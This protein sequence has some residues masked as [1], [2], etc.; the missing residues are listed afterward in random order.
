MVV[1]VAHDREQIEQ[2]RLDRTKFPGP[3]RQRLAELAK[4]PLFVARIGADAPFASQCFDQTSR[5]LRA[6]IV[7]ALVQIVRV[8]RRLALKGSPVG[9]PSQTVAQRLP[10]QHAW[11]ITSM[12]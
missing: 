12:A 3:L 2:P 9:R 11:L 10:E 6:R 4:H 8:P 1:A 7:V 5:E